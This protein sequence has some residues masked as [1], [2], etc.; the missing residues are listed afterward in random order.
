MKA[1]KI[2]SVKSEQLNPLPAPSNEERKDQ[3]AP[4]QK[5][6][7]ALAEARLTINAEGD[8]IPHMH[9]RA[10]ALCR[11]VED[12]ALGQTESEIS[13]DALAKVM[14]IVQEDLRV[15]KW[16]ASGRPLDPRWD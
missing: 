9:R 10:I 7:V 4:W 12:M 16:L 2:I 8:L 13:E 1:K 15:A 11:I 6:I 14:E 5:E 3:L